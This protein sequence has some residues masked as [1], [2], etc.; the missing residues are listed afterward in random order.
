MGALEWM[1]ACCQYSTSM[2]RT[3]SAVHSMMITLCYTGPYSSG[4][5]L[6]GLTAMRLDATLLLGFA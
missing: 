4:L 1:S 2:W 3:C 5:L 6:Q